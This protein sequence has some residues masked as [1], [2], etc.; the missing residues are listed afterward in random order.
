MSTLSGNW[1][2]PTLIQFGAGRIQELA[3]ACQGLGMQAPLFITDRGLSEMPLLWTEVEACQKAGLR[4]AV[5][6]DIKPNPVG[7]N[8]TEGVAV[9][10]QGQHDGIIAFGG[11]SA[12]DAGKAIALM[13]GQD[14]PLW[15]FV[16]EGD[17]WTR[18]N[19][20][21]M[22]PVIAVPTTSGTGA[23]VGRASV[24]TNEDCH[25]KKI[26]FH[27]NMM[28]GLVIADPA[29][30]VG[31]PPH[32]T[33]ATGMDALSHLLEAYCA[34]GYHPMADGIAL[35]GMRLVKEWL[36]IAYQEPEN[37]EARSHMMVASTMGATAFQK[38]LGGMHALAHPLGGLY[39]AHHGLLN[40]I[41]MPYVL[42][43]NQS[44]IDE[45]MITLARH[46]NLKET[47]FNSALDWVV[48][49]RSKLK[50]P[51]SLSD[52]GIN[53]NEADE[54]A[55]RA[56]VDPAAGGNPIEITPENI[57]PVFIDAVNGTL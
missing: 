29:L 45:R 20:D 35:E 9:Y 53:D 11:G 22:A 44:K 41:L 17:N 21:G 33:A 55:K 27:A 54:V 56:A 18:V 7:Q 26:I 40:A 36:P 43:F 30:T 3:I 42:R 23:E 15:D 46:L 38:G 2:Y 12:L 51:Q 16:D 14:R 52:I 47:N 57:Q 10:K 5:F 32:L 4:A 25:S 1:N 24:I 34:P 6:S 49:L 28:P 19:V 37:I 48:E 50:I 31:L 13:V 39:D 8:I